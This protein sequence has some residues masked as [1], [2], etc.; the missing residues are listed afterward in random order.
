[1]NRV[2]ITQ[3]MI[4][5]CF[6]QVCAVKDAADPEILQVCNSLNVSGTSGGWQRVIREIDLINEIDEKYLP[7]QCEQ[8]PERI[9]YLIV[10]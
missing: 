10:C 4:G 1:M 2:E 6:M 5:I 9:H 8:D 3:P 7:K